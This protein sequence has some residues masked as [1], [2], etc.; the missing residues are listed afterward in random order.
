MECWHASPH[1]NLLDHIEKSFLFA[2]YYSTVQV[3]I[4]CF[5]CRCKPQTSKALL[6]VHLEAY[7]RTNTLEISTSHDTIS[8]SSYPTHQRDFVLKSKRNSSSLTRLSKLLDQE[9]FDQTLLIILTTM[10]RLFLMWVEFHIVHMVISWIWFPLGLGPVGAGLLY[11]FIDNKTG[12]HSCWKARSKL[13]LE[14]Q[15]EPKPLS[16]VEHSSTFSCLQVFQT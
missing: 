4:L 10:R 6:S 2:G 1:C 16:P 14:L 15:L 7:Q 3:K 5:V 11:S 13:L 8:F 9:L 12:A